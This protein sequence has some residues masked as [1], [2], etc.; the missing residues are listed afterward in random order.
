MKIN[1]IDENKFIIILFDSIIIDDS[2]CFKELFKSFSEILFKKYKYVFNGLYSV[3]IYN[4]KN[5]SIFKFINTMD[6]YLLDFDI[7]VYKNSLLLFEFFDYELFDGKKVYFDNKYYIEYG[8]V[9]N[10]FDLFE[11]GNIIYGD[12]VNNILNNGILID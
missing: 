1:F 4:N 3:Y 8:D 6:D 5:I 2:L 9:C 10:R 11:Y 7:T 12:S